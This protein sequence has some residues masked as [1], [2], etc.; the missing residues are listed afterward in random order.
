MLGEYSS[1]ME[2]VRVVVVESEEGLRG[3][4]DGILF[5]F[6]IKKGMERGMVY[7]CSIIGR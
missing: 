4:W 3:V 7:D 6:S 2:G 5:G 1:F